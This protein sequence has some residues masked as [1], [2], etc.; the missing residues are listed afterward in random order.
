[1][2][3]PMPQFLTFYYCIYPTSTTIHLS[4]RQ[5]SIVFPVKIYTGDESLSDTIQLFHGANAVI[6]YHGAG[7]ANAVFCQNGTKIVEISAVLPSGILWRS[8]VEMKG[9]GKD[10]TKYGRFETLRIGIPVEKLVKANN[11]TMDDAKM[12]LI[13]KPHL[14]LDHYVK[15]LQ[16]VFADDEILTEITSFLGS[17][18]ALSKFEDGLSPA[19]HAHRPNPRVQ[20]PKLTYTTF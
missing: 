12:D 11:K 17:T 15:D 9:K 6:G 2:Y 10:V 8:N 16:W 7:L 1:M 4:V 18:D 13:L 14:D 19:L 5:I 20:P 3:A